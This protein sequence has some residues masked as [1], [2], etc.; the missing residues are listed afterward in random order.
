MT[1]LDRN[2]GVAAD[3]RIAQVTERYEA[4]S[5]GVI[6]LSAKRRNIWGASSEAS[7]IQ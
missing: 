5:Y 6:S 7:K 2:L 4:G 1:V 3:M